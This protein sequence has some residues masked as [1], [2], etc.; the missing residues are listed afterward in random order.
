MQIDAHQHFWAY[1]KQHYGWIDDSMQPLQRDFLPADLKALLNENDLDG[2]VAVQARESFSETDF[3]LA[4]AAAHPWIKKV[5]GWLDLRSELLE[6]ELERLE[7]VPAL[8]GFRQVLQHLDPEVL[9]DSRFRAGLKRMQ[10]NDY[11]FDLLIYPQHLSA[12]T[13]L[14]TDYPD[15]RFVIDHLA[16]P[17]IA[18]GGLQEWSRSISAIAKREN[19][20]CKLSGMVTEADWKQ[21][22]AEQLH[23]YM[24]VAFAAFGPQR[25]MYGSDWPV[26]L[27]AGQYQEVKQVVD[28]YL[29][30]F[31]DDEKQRVMGG[32]ACEFYGIVD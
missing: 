3:L 8:A 5:V 30:A 28:N 1:D 19:V 16:K 9:D 11:T 6:P 13:R 14:V 17:R 7:S 20:F 27:L 24:D 21:W 22:T 23:P 4:L 25:L 10:D 12:V 15:Q 29:E 2:C 18:S 32:T 26:A 31:S